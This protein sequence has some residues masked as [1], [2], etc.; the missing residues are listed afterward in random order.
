MSVM[1]M[2]GVFNEKLGWGVCR[3]KSVDGLAIL[4]LDEV[5]ILD[6]SGV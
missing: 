1:E 6:Q 5:E 2:S 3:E 4:L